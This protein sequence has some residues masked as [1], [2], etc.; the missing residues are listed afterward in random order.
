MT[1]Q[2]PD[3]QTLPTLTQEQGRKVSELLQA[4]APVLEVDL[5]C[6]FTERLLNFD[7]VELYD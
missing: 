4:V 3:M 7:I 1:S 5:M 2:K 6:D